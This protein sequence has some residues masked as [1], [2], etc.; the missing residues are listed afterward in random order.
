MVQVILKLPPMVAIRLDEAAGGPQKRSRF[1]R[2]LLERRLAASA[3][4]EQGQASVQ[5]NIRVGAKELGRLQCAAT[6]A[7]MTRTEW[8]VALI[9]RHHFATP[10]FPR[11]DRIAL[12]EVHRELHRIGALLR[13]LASNRSMVRTPGSDDEVGA[14]LL[15]A[16]AEI[17]HQLRGL[18]RGIEGNFEY[19]SADL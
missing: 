11:T 10:Q 5:I 15:A 16:V 9:R 3:A 7:G 1:V 8:I 13:G 12:M 2:L 17:E 6:A 19:W 14:R 4:Y 18:R